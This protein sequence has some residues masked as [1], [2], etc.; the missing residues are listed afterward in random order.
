M[1][2]IYFYQKKKSLYIHLSEEI[3]FGNYLCYYNLK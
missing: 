3:D 1:F 2:H